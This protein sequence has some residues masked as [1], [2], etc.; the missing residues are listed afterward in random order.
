M[1]VSVKRSKK[2]QVHVEKFESDQ[3][4]EVEDESEEEPGDDMVEIKEEIDEPD[5]ED[6]VSDSQ[7]L[8]DSCEDVEIKEEEDDAESEVTSD[9]ESD[10]KIDD[11]SDGDD[12]EDESASSNEKDCDSGSKQKGEKHVRMEVD[13]SEDE[14][15]TDSDEEDDEF[16]EPKVKAESDT[17]DVKSGLADVMAQILSMKGGHNLILSKAKKDYMTVKPEDTGEFQ[18]VDAD[19]NVKQEIKIKV[20]EEVDPSEVA[21]KRLLEKENLIK[22]FK[23]KPDVERDREKERKL[24]ITATQGV[25]QLFTAIEKHKAL[26]RKQRSETK[27]LVAREEISSSDVKES[28]LDILDKEGEKLKRS[29]DA[30]LVKEELKSEPIDLPSAAKKPK[31]NVFADNFYKEPTL[32]GWDLQSDEEA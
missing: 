1:A 25:V 2:P 7:G 14:T 28:F 11:I 8:G 13:S 19:G 4:D 32:Q 3:S 12:S 20:E 17:E 10:L 15:E 24:R 5:D 16:G 9:D 27:S 6:L 26:I 23:L 30:K 22:K 29:R 21:R 31:W 18:V